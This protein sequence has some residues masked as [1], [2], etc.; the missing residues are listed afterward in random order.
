MP[1]PSEDHGERPPFCFFL[2]SVALVPFIP[3]GLI[4]PADS[5]FTTVS[6]ELPPGS[7]LESTLRVAE[8]ARAA[9]KDV[10]GIDSVLTTV[11]NGQRG[12]AGPR[13]QAGEVRN[14]ALILTLSPRDERPEQVE[15]ENALRARLLNVPGARFNVGAGRLG[16]K[17]EL[18][19]SSDDAEALKATA[20]TLGSAIGS[21]GALQ[22]QHHRQP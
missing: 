12:A 1:G 2:A 19:L 4:P 5:G 18:I 9:I 11:G 7:S 3:T 15:I 22:H 6:I 14:A 16:E 8:Q 13:G 17:I 21:A 10:P 20:Q